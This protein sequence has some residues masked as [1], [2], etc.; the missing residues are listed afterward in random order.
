MSRE[1]DAQYSFDFKL[2]REA[3]RSEVQDGKEHSINPLCERVDRVLEKGCFKSQSKSSKKYTIDHDYEDCYTSRE[4]RRQLQ[5]RSYKSN[6]HG[7][8]NKST[9]KSKEDDSLAE[10]NNIINMQSDKK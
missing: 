7:R 5:S 3:I 2:M 8:I 4:E 1:G 10:L 9:T 6:L